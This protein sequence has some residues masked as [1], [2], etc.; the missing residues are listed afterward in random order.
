[1]SFAVQTSAFTEGGA[2]P[3]KY[4]CD[5]ADVSPELTWANAPAGTQSFALTVTDPDAPAGT[6][7]HWVAWN[8]P[9]ST[10]KLSEGVSKTEKLPDGTLQGKND[11]KR[12][13]YNGP[14][15]PPGK[16]HRYFFKLY[17][18]GTKLDL[19]PGASRGELESALKGH[20]L[21]QAEAMGKYGR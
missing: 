5:G 6:W 12:I 17:A 18:L 9:A 4:T 7:T 1:M 10:T 16:P 20:I 21:G 11:F 2:I 15:P 13:G 14:C 8:I 3:K 19:N